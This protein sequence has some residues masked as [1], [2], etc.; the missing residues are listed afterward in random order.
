MNKPLLILI[1]LLYGCTV[2]DPQ[3][4]QA[5]AIARQ[6]QRDYSNK[7][8]YNCIEHTA[9]IIR[10]CAVQGIALV[11]ATFTR[12]YH[13]SPV[14]FDKQTHEA[15]VIDST[16]VMS[17]WPVRLDHIYEETGFKLRKMKV[18]R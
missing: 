1:M 7:P 16:G 13:K 2:L 10:R 17:R 4:K 8:D 11:P 5:Q 18:K 14:W 12:D 3:V 9:E 15:W 6:V